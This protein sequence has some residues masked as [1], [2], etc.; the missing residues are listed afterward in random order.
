MTTD[1][2][3]V[4]AIAVFDP[5]TKEPLCFCLYQLHTDAQ[6]AAEV[7]SAL[8]WPRLGQ[9]MGGAFWMAAWEAYGGLPNVDGMIRDQL[10]ALAERGVRVEYRAEWPGV[11]DTGAPAPLTNIYATIDDALEAF[12]VTQH[13]SGQSPPLAVTP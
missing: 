13:V 3:T 8:S 12:E 7:T 10:A 2:S 1:P 11:P 5:K 6:Q 4:S 9:I